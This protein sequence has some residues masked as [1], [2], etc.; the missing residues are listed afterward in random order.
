MGQLSTATGNPPAA[1]GDPSASPLASSSTVTSPGKKANSGAVSSTTGMNCSAYDTLPHASVAVHCRYHV[2][3]QLAPSMTASTLYVTSP[4]VSSLAPPSFNMNVGSD[5]KST[6]SCVHSRG[7][8]DSL[9]LAQ[10]G[11]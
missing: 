1:R 3:E 9:G 6:K 8:K 4:L 7:S 11:A 2:P 10:T 5:I